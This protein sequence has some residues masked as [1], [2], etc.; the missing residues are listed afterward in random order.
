M[1]H[2]FCLILPSLG[3]KF[4]YQHIE[5]VLLLRDL[6]FIWRYEVS[7]S[8]SQL[9]SQSCSNLIACLACFARWTKKKETLIVVYSQTYRHIIFTGVSKRSSAT[10]H[11][12]EYI[13][14]LKYTYLKVKKTYSYTEQTTTAQV[15]TEKKVNLT[16]LLSQDRAHVWN[17]R[18]KKKRKQLAVNCSIFEW[19]ACSAPVSP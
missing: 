4:E 15:T 13:S 16:S 11:I 8:G 3:V 12:W 2:F 14:K 9:Q 18:P 5:I 10:W 6:T 1:V 19:C 17:T 7:T